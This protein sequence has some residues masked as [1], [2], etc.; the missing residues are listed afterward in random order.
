MLCAIAALAASVGATGD[1]RADDASGRPTPAT[2]KTRSA[3]T[4]TR[5]APAYRVV[6]PLEVSA[7]AIMGVVSAGW[8]LR[9]ELSPVSCGPVCPK[10]RVNAFDRPFAGRY[11]APATFVS[12][13]AVVATVGGA[14]ATVLI[15]E[16]A[17]SGANDAFVVLETIVSGITTA[18]VSN[19]S[20]RR[21]RPYMYGTL[22]PLEKRTSGDGGLSFFSGHATTAS[23]A[24]V[25]LFMTLR[26]LHPGASWPG[27]FLAGGA[28][29]VS[30]VGVGRIVGGHHFPTDVLA[31]V[32]V[33]SA[34][35]VLVPTLHAHP[36][37]V[38]PQAGADGPG[39]TLVGTF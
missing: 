2:A 1:A 18:I 5:V 22:A 4:K 12:D 21:P 3:A 24:A 35:G 11:S 25:G 7:L 23:A 19:T 27:W 38:V 6:W 39:L 17:G 10:D 20:V 36:V 26:R 31:G 29:L 14:L 13:L 33:G 37:R 9:G 16:G 34:Y 8:V 32:A 30:A 15:D 28:A